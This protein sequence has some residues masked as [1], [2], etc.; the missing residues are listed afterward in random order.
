MTISNTTRKLHLHRHR[1]HRH[2]MPIMSMPT[3][4]EL[5]VPWEVMESVIMRRLQTSKKQA[6]VDSWTC[7]AITGRQSNH[8]NGCRYRMASYPSWTIQTIFTT[9]LR[10]DPVLVPPSKSIDGRDLRRKTIAPRRLVALISDWHPLAMMI[11]KKMSRRA[12]AKK[13]CL[14]VIN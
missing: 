10:H 13:I 12:A 5:S 9:Y 3:V 1:I 8:I 6:V 4:W 7:C 2:K 14:L 11:G